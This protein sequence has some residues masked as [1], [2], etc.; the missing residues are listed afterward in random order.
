V[1]RA[2]ARA[3]AA[4]SAAVTVAMS[5]MSAPTRACPD[6]APV[7]ACG[8]TCCDPAQPPPSH[9]PPPPAPAQRGGDVFLVEMYDS[10]F[11]PAKLVIRPSSVV[12]WF[13]AGLDFHTATRDG[14][15]DSGLVPHKGVYDFEFTSATAGFSYS[16]TCLLHFGMDG[17]IYVARYGDADLD[18]DVDLADF[19]TLASNFGTFGPPWEGGDFNEDG[20]VNLADFNLL[21]ANFGRDIEPAPTSIVIDFPTSVPEPATAA[22]LPLVALAVRARKGRPFRDQQ[23]DR[24]RLERNTGIRPP[25]AATPGIDAGAAGRTRR[26]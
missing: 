6:G 17:V 26:R 24:E 23:R 16:Y 5:A 3:V 7:D 10:F 11:A 9:A 18:G 13:N 20:A 22:L 4:L 25:A 15:F 12:R 8:T 1:A 21:A 14:M 2:P 19:N